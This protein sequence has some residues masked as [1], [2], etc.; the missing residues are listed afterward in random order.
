MTL[1]DWLLVFAGFG[2]AWVLPSPISAPPFIVL[3]PALLIGLLLLRVLM[4]FALVITLVVL[5]RQLLYGREVRPAEW[6]V[7][8]AMSLT[9]CAIV[10]D[11]DNTLEAISRAVT[12]QGA[13]HFQ[14]W[15]SFAAL[16]SLNAALVLLIACTYWRRVMP[17]VLKTLGLLVAVAAFWWG[18]ID[19]FER[20]LP[21]PSA[22]VTD[23]QSAFLVE[24]YLA[25]RSAWAAL[26]TGLLFGI[27]VVA[28]IRSLVHRR[29]R[30]IWTEWAAMATAGL[31]AALYLSVAVFSL[32]ESTPA[33]R[34]A[35][36][37]VAV[38]WLTVIATLGL[39]VT[40]AAK[41]CNLRRCSTTS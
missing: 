1:L 12:G 15:R 32:F 28:A 41:R 3:S 24:L 29:R 37:L 14:L 22:S 31:L 6:L 23:W 27:P 40:R 30:H 34:T 38:L 26:P 35:D 39:A 25:I 5:G 11:I 33:E 18:P 9:L 20:K 8:F 16:V 17:P 36:I 13:V 2:I 10:P 19:M 21:F 7:V 4:A